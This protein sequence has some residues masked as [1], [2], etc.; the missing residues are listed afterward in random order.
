MVSTAI[1]AQYLEGCSFPCSRQELINF[2]RSKNAPNDVLNTLQLLP[3]RTY[4]SMAGVWDAIGEV[5]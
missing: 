2:A 4:N 3:D 5:S 1:I